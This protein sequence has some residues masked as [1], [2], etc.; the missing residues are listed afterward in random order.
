[1]KLHNWRQRLDNR[2]A[3]IVRAERRPAGREIVIV[4]LLS[5]L[6]KGATVFIGAALIA[7]V[8]LMIA[9]YTS[10]AGA[11]NM[12]VASG[13]VSYTGGLAQ[14]A[15]RKFISGGFFS[16][17]LAYMPELVAFWRTAPWRAEGPAPFI[18]SEWSLG[19]TV[20][21]V[22]IIMC[23]QALLIFPLVHFTSDALGDTAFNRQIFS[24]ERIQ[25]RW[26]GFEEVCKPSP[27][28]LS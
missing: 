18:L 15:A 14:A 3:R 12:C 4:Q 6:G 13:F 10:L 28:D 7:S 11:S 19:L 24:R 22:G 17:L 21:A 25:A 9:A 8:A 26:Q 5:G 27:L 16:L 20:R 2:R 23:L 1:M